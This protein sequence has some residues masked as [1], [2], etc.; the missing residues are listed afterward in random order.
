MKYFA[1][2]VLTLIAL[3]TVAVVWIAVSWSWRVA[4]ALHS[5]K[6]PTISS[7]HRRSS[8]KFPSPTSSRGPSPSPEVV[9]DIPVS[10]FEP[11]PL[12]ISGEGSGDETV[13]VELSSGIWTVDLIWGDGA[14][15]PN[16]CGVGHHRL[17]R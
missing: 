2:A 5:W 6:K 16:W 11:M 10:E 14:Q 13:V 15:P 3:Q 17:G 12:T 9:R 4:R 7:D 1:A 8:G